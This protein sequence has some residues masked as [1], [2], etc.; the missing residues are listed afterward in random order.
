MPILCR[1]KAN[2]LCCSDGTQRL[3][4]ELDV[5]SR[6]EVERA[7][8]ANDFEWSAKVLQE[9]VEHPKVT[10]LPRVGVAHNQNNDPEQQ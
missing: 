8:L 5:S 4:S 9:D 10:V 2:P 1:R 6:K 7:R 3:V